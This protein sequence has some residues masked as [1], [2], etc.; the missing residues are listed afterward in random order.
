M[1]SRLYPLHKFTILTTFLACFLSDG[2]ANC[3]NLFSKV[4]VLQNITFLQSLGIIGKTSSCNHN[5]WSVSIEFWINLFFFLNLKWIIKVRSLFSLVIISYIF[6]WNSS[7]HL[8]L[9]GQ[10]IV[11]F[12]NSGLL[13]GLLSFSLGV[14]TY[15]IYTKTIIKHNHFSKNIYISSLLELTFFVLSLIFLTTNNLFP[16]Q[17]FVFPILASIS[18][19]FFAHESGF[20]SKFLAK[21]KW[22][23]DISYSVYLNQLTI[24]L[25]YKSIKP[26]FENLDIHLV[27]ILIL[28]IIYS[29]C[30]Y[31]LIEKPFQRKMRKMIR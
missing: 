13:R 7:D 11:P 29:L 12:I 20:M 23:G 25:V 31:Q 9:I 1:D 4:D 18:V 6:L 10:E 15:K 22:L 21:L 27:L 28:L 2:F 26:K 5:S 19:F 3:Y 8:N 14:I 30:T 24:F 17:D 16:M